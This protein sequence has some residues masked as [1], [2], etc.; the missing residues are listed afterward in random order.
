MKHR[1]QTHRCSV[2]MRLRIDPL[3]IC[4]IPMIDMKG[5]WPQL[6]SD[7]VAYKTTFPCD[8]QNSSAVNLT[9][10]LTVGTT[11]IIFFL[12]YIL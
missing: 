5:R 4:H 8:L 6:N 10:T 3:M 1:Q 2:L 7:P 12:F 9:M 11:Q